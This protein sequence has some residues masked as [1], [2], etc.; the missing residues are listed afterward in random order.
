[1]MGGLVWDQAGTN[2]PLF[3]AE[4]Q[5]I[6]LFL[7]PPAKRWYPGA[8]HPWA[9]G[10]AEHLWAPGRAVTRCHASRKG[11]CGKVLL[12]KWKKRRSGNWQERDQEGGM[13]GA[14]RV[15]KR[16]GSGGGEGRGVFRAA[17]QGLS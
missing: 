8:E 2:P 1:M 15:Q 4:N 12:E 6:S 9:R 14:E 3:S 11:G 5:Q 16:Q 10:R 13:S 7:A 17:A